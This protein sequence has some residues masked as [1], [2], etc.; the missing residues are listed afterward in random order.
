MLKDSIQKAINDQINAELYSSYIYL[1]M[2][3]YLE[4]KNFKGMAHWFRIQAQEELTHVVKLI[5]YMNDRDGKVV[6][7]VVDAPPT[8]WESPLAAFS[9]ALAHERT[10]TERINDL[11]TLAGNEGDRLTENFLQWFVAEQVEEEA[12]ASEIVGQL[13]LVGDNGSGL[14]MIDRELGQR[15]FTP[16]AGIKI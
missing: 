14:F 6:L 8:E 4:S 9:N 2:S 7:G 12:T 1:S 5:D 10:V 13:E 16:P 3:G 15:V 11:V